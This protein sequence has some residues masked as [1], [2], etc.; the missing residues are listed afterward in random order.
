MSFSRSPLRVALIAQVGGGIA[1][2]ALIRLVYPQLSGIPLAAAALQGVCAAL[3]GNWLGSP[4]WWLPIHCGFLPAVVLASRLEIAPSWY[5]AAFVLLLLV[6]WRT[7]QS[8]VP[9]YLS[10]AATALALEQLLPP[11]P[12]QVV[13]L[14]CGH[15][16]LL[17]RLARARCDCRFVGIEHA[18]LPWLW[19]RLASLAQAN[20]KIR[21]G[22]FWQQDL[23][24]FDIVYVFLSPVPMRRLM[25]KARAEMRSGTLL[26]SN[27]FAVPGQT[28]ER[29]V[30]VADRRSTQLHCYRL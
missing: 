12:C 1:A 27:S 4:K 6:Y 23:A 13:D 30:A 18:P 8:R 10:N 29:V 19:A 17:R 26:V 9:L 7:D 25:N 2:A 24:A 14:G 3:I 5:L 16:G 15:G 28:P 22:D 11:Q 20:L 21:Y